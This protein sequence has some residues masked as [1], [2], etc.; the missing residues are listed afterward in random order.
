MS[1]RSVKEL[2]GNDEIMIEGE[3]KYVERDSYKDGKS[4]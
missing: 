3:K 1:R 4:Y 2:W